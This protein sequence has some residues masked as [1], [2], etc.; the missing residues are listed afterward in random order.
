MLLVVSY[1]DFKLLSKFSDE[2][3]IMSP[4]MLNKQFLKKG[5]VLVLETP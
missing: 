3:R 2:N 1:L 4:C 5:G